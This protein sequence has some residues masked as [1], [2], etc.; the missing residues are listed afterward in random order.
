MDTNTKLIYTIAIENINMVKVMSVISDI[1]LNKVN[2]KTTDLLVEIREGFPE[3]WKNNQWIRYFA[4]VS[5]IEN[6]G[7]IESVL[8]EIKDEFLED[9]ICD[10]K[11]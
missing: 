5:D 3:Y 2:E 11:E 8:K 4:G 9:F 10:S 7:F 6:K 1:M